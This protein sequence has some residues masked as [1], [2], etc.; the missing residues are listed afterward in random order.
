MDSSFDYV[1]NKPIDFLKLVY[2]DTLL[3]TTKTTV[4]DSTELFCANERKKSRAGDHLLSPVHMM[5]RLLSKHDL[6][7]N[8]A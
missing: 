6:R 8:V 1:L 5:K 7:P 2:T 4:A 3:A